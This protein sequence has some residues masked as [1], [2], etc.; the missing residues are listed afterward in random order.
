MKTQD[1]SVETYSIGK[2]STTSGK[3][4]DLERDG[5]FSRSGSGMASSSTVVGGVWGK[6]ETSV[7][8][9]EEPLREGKTWEVG[10]KREGKDGDGRDGPRFPS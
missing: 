1:V 7:G 2:E 8:G 4:G 6:S 9:D 10:R 3:V 5:A